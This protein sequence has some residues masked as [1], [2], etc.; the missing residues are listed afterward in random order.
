MAKAKQQNY[1]AKGTLVYPHL[2][3]ADTKFNAAG[4]YSTKLRVD[5]AEHERLVGILGP[6]RDAHVSDDP[7]SEGRE[8][9]RKKMPFKKDKESGL[10]DWSFK[11]RATF[12]KADGEVIEFSVTIIDAGTKPT[13][14]NPWGGTVAKIRFTAHPYDMSSSETYGLSLRPNC[15]QII[16]LVTGSGTGNTEGFD[17]EEGFTDDGS[18]VDEEVEAPVGSD[19]SD[20]ADF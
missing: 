12:T 5:A 20:G 8:E 7:N 11:Q 3:V 18:F 1:F 16:E 4:E 9:W 6:V 19:G 13:N 14:A 10:Y 15:V 2:K 17:E